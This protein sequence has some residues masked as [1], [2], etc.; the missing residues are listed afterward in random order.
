MRYLVPAI[1]AALMVFSIAP[2]RAGTDEEQV[3]AVLDGMNASYNG[4]DFDAFASHVCADMRQADGFQAGWYQSRKTDGPTSITIMSVALAGTPPSRA[5]ANVR[6]AAA[7]HTDPKTLT[8]DFVR[9][10]AEW[11]ACRYHAASSI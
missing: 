3:R 1:T 11:K 2:A 10:S 8:V 6:F 9:E 4:S 7:N 5:I